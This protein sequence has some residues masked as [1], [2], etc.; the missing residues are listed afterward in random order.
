[1]FHVVLFEPEIPPNTG[2]IIRLCANS[3]STL[4]LIHPLGFQLDDKHL[5]RA[6]M[7]Y[8]E[9]ASVREHENL[10]DF[11]HQQPARLFACSTRAGQDY[12]EAKFQADDAFLFGPETRGLPQELLDSLPPERLLRIPMV[13]GSRSLNL[14]NSVAVVLYE[15]WRQQGFRGSGR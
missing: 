7:D 6:G 4:H 8:S 3:G 5:R 14:S 1:M 11:Q 10:E 13:A 2:N 9:L 15:A 12:S